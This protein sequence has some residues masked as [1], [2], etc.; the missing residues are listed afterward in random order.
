MNIFFKKILL[1]SFLIVTSFVTSCNKTVSVKGDYVHRP[2]DNGIAEINQRLD[3]IEPKANEA[4]ANSV[5]ST[6]YISTN[7]LY[8]SSTNLS[9]QLVNNLENNISNSIFTPSWRNLD[10]FD[11]TLVDVYSNV[12]PANSYITNQDWVTAVYADNQVR[13]DKQIILK[14]VHDYPIITYSVIPTNLATVSSNGYIT[15]K[16]VGIITSVVSSATFSRTNILYLPMRASVEAVYYQGATGS[17]R[18][19]AEDNINLYITN[20]T[21]RIFSTYN[22]SE[23]IFVRSTNLWFR[24]SPACV[25]VLNNN[26]YKGGVLI[27]PKHMISATHY[28]VPPI[29]SNVIFVTTNN[30]VITNTVINNASLGSDVSITRFSDSITITPAKLLTNFYAILPTGTL[31]IPMGMGESHAGSPYIQIGLGNCTLS[32]LS[33]WNKY[34]T[35]WKQTANT[36]LIPYFYHY[37]VSGDSSQPML[38]S[39]GTDIILVGQFYSSWGGTFTSA[40]ASS[41]QQQITSWGDTN[42]ISYI[43]N[44]LWRNF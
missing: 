34:M 16:A 15:H 32:E 24:P 25:A 11:M 20:A 19:A 9:Y 31:E 33:S 22:V 1:I 27:T 12:P 4:L 5:A 3:V 38:I 10:Y 39:T 44:A 8:E 26:R 29:G 6:N 13:N 36:L 18:R 2:E 43:N 21:M 30:I 7:L 40:L 23:R 41:I 35:T 17:I 42:T 14:N 28:G 37:P